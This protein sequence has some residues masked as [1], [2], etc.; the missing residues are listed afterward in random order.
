MKYHPTSEKL[1]EV[2]TGGDL[3]NYKYNDNLD[4]V[5][6]QKNNDA[7]IE[8]T[9][10]D[11]GHITKMTTTEQILSFDYNSYG[12]P[13][14]IMVDGQGSIT[15]KYDETGRIE[16]VKSDDD[17]QETSFIVTQAFQEL[18]EVIKPSGVDLGM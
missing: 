4:L 3:F 13:V 17:K 1:T 10:D 9:Y 12:K 5:Y 11:K 8:L 7:P 15:I 16:N 14:K 18:M 2:L 6:A